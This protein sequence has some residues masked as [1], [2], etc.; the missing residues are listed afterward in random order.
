MEY[1]W[2]TDKFVYK[3]NIL[4]EKK[5][6]QI[7]SCTRAIFD[8]HLHIQADASNSTSFQNVIE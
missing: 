7:Q 5:Q 2:L 4:K 1:L 3:K 6:T 8:F